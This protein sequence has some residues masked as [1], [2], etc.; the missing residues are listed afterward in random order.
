MSQ[1]QLAPPSPPSPQQLAPQ[2]ESPSSLGPYTLDQAVAAIEEMHAS[3][4]PA[5]DQLVRL[6]CV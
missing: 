5:F 1:Q 6:A 4:D 3:G 2:Q